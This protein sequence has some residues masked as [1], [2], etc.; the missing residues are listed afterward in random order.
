M[1]ENT[2]VSIKMI[3]LKKITSESNRKYTKDDGFEQLMGSIQKHGIIEPPVL[4]FTGAM[5]MECYNVIAGR[6][7]IEAAKRLGRKEE[8]CIVYVKEDSR[9]N[10]EIALAEN[11]NRQ[12]MHPL[13][14]AALFQH[15]ADN[16]STVEEISKYYARSQSAIYKRLRLSGLDEELK[17]MFRDGIINIAGAAVLAE[18]PE[19]DQKVFF[20]LN[21]NKDKEIEKSAIFQFVNKKQRFT[22]KECIKGCTNCSK[23]THNQGNELFDEYQHLDDVCLDADCYRVKWYEM[24]SAA[25]LIQIKQM[26]EGGVQTDNKVYF[27]GGIPELLYKKA[28]HVNLENIRYDILRDKDYD[29]TGETNKK[30]NACWKVH[31]DYNGKIDVRR[32]GYKER[33][34]R[35]KTIVDDDKSSNVNVNDYGR[36]TMKVLAD[37][38]GITSQEL[39]KKLKDK[40]ISDYNFRNDIKDMVFERVIERRIELEKTG[41]EPPHDY[42]TMFMRLADEEIY[43]DKSFLERNFN[44]VQKKWYKSLFGEKTIKQIFD[45]L[46]GEA[47]QLFHFLML[48]IGFSREAP[49]LDELKNIDKKDNIFWQYASMSIDEYKELY[50]DAAN[51][52][53]EKALKPKEK[54]EAK[55]KAG[56]KAAAAHGDSNE[57]D[58]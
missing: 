28:T 20:K 40:K 25:I 56:E 41:K 30:K 26:T 6:R 37:Y 39:A 49:D 44:D 52:V 32:V 5:K 24:I 23:R 53:T 4:R 47:Q 38:N 8:L 10:E 7:R 3:E 22:I 12:E 48:S 16:G 14:E 35:E 43:G 45:G 50:F 36:E 51:E 17:G 29:F 31:C 1:S 54:K 15:M 13:D 18:L 55:K 19:G 21:K 46:S 9:N 57:E 33:L 11:I 42:L 34:Q 2:T 27:T 58:S